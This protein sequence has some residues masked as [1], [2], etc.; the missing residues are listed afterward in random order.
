MLNAPA[1]CHR[2]PASHVRSQF[3]IRGGTEVHRRSGY[4]G[5]AAVCVVD[6][7]VSREEV[8]CSA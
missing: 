1:S 5:D 2:L 4:C 6:E 3:V 7:A 8:P